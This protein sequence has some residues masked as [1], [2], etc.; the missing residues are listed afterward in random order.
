MICAFGAS[1]S[2]W[3]II[4]SAKAQLDRVRWMSYP[5]VSHLDTV[6]RE[7]MAVADGLKQ[8]DPEAAAEAMKI[9]ID[10]VFTM[11]R[12]LIIE[13]RDYFATDSGEVL[14]GYVKRQ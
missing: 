7:H 6:L 11:I 5:L 10:R 13:R 3:K 8:R 9:H 4:N 14:D 1:A 2:V 12:R